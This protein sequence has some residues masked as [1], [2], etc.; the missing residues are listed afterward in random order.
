MM[1]IG[2]L[3][4]RMT[5]DSRAVAKGLDDIGSMP[6]ART[7]DVLFENTNPVDLV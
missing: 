3:V 2:L 5:V 6:V 4:E 7:V 1:P